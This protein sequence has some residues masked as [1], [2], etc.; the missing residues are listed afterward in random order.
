MEE[1]KPSFLTKLN[2]SPSQLWQNHK[3]FLIGFG[4][5]IL[6]IKF[7][8]VI[9]DLLVNSSKKLVDES[10]KKSDNLQQQQNAANNQANQLVKEADDLGKNRPEVDENWHKK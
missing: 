10:Q 2:M 8:D 4:L 3:W 9:F 5:L 7:Q 1:N 6:V